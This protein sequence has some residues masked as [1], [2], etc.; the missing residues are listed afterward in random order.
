[1]NGW[2]YF[3]WLKDIRAWLLEAGARI[4]EINDDFE[5]NGDWYLARWREGKAPVAV[6]NLVMGNAFLEAT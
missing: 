4:N 6:A 3:L 5:E 1:M 2:G